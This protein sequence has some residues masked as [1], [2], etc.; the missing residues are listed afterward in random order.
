M[1]AADPIGANGGSAF[2]PH[3]FQ[4]PSG[5]VAGM[6][7]RVD[8]R[9]GVHKP[10]ANERLDGVRGVER[11]LDTELHGQ[12]NDDSV[13]VIR[14]YPARGV[15][16]AGARTLASTDFPEWRFVHVR[17]L[18]LMIEESIDQATQ[19]AVFE[20]NRQEMWRAID[21]AVRNFLDAQWRAGRLDGATPED[22][23]TVVCDESTNPEREANL[24][25][26]TCVISVA[27]PQPAEVV[28]VRLGRGHGDPNL[29][30]T[31]RAAG[32]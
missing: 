29:V 7:A 16:V 15:R 17:R 1:Y 9:D 3:T 2:S 6:V 18:L 23:F 27:P 13:N 30:Q 8:R 28:V 31:G 19:W 21:R 4:P 26:F 25:R 14:A 24:G 22:A 12:L 10:P 20:S 32:G 11:D 5:H